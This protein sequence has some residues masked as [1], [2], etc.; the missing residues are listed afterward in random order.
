MN[1]KRLIHPIYTSIW[2]IQHIRNGKVIWFDVGK[3][4]LVQQGEEQILETYFR[5]G[6]LFIPSQFYVRLCNETLLITSTLTSISTEPSGSGYAPQLLER[7]TIGFPTK[8]LIGGVYRLTS[9]MLSFT[10]SGGQIGP[11]NAAYLATTLDNTGSLIAFRTLSMARTILDGD[12]M[13]L[14]FRVQLS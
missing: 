14:Q 2:T 3:N 7:S 1:E 13:T 11:V 6:V 5:A 4:S 10:A 8:E 9:K 12:T